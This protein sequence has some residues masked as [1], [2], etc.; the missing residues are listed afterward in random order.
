MTICYPVIQD[1]LEFCPREEL[2]FSD[3]PPTCVRVIPIY[4]DI[5]YV[6]GQFPPPVHFF[7]S[8]SGDVYQLAHIQSPPSV[9]PEYH[10]LLDSTGC[11]LVG[12][13]FSNLRRGKIL[14]AQIAVLPGVL[15]H[16]LQT[17]GLPLTSVQNGLPPDRCNPQQ[18]NQIVAATQNCLLQ[19]PPPPFDPCAFVL[20]CISGGGQP[21]QVQDTP[22]LDLTLTGNVLSGQVVV[23]PNAGNQLQVLPNGL[24]VSASASINVVDTSTVDLT[25]SGGNLSAQVVLNPSTNNALTATPTGLFVPQAPIQNVANT[26]TVALNVS[27]GT[28]TANA[29][30]APIA[31]NLLQALPNGLYVPP[32]V[33]TS[34]IINGGQGSWLFWDG[35]NYRSANLDQYRVPWGDV[36]NVNQGDLY[37]IFNVNSLQ[38]LRNNPPVPTAAS[39][40]LYISNDATISNFFG[41]NL[42][43]FQ[44]WTSVSNGA[45]GNSDLML[46]SASINSISAA[47]SSIKISRSS[48][49][50][51]LSLQSNVNVS[52]SSLSSTSI[53]NSNVIIENSNISGLF[54]FSSNCIGNGVAASSAFVYSSTV[55]SNINSSISGA[56]SVSMISDVPSGI[57]N[58]DFIDGFFGFHGNSFLTIPSQMQLRHGFAQFSTNQI[59]NVPVIVF[60]GSLVTITGS[61]S[62]NNGS[63][64]DIRDSVVATGGTSY[65]GAGNRIPST[66]YN[67]LVVGRLNLNTF[68]YLEAR[69]S[70]VA[71]S[72]STFSQ[73]PLTRS[74]YN[75][76]L[77]TG[78]NT[79]LTK[80]FDSGSIFVGAETTESPDN[81]LTV[82]GTMNLT[83]PE[84]NAGGYRILTGTNNI[85]TFEVWRSR[86]FLEQHLFYFGTDQASNYANDAAAVAI[87]NLNYGSDPRIKFG[88][89]TVVNVA[90]TPAI[91][92]WN[93]ATFVRITV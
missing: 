51:L 80:A 20:Q 22:T 53:S 7:I 91:F 1:R 32:P 41:Q 16:I 15:R 36:P 90:G 4:Q 10:A 23:S 65:G 66:V 9:P 89:M 45:A 56:L 85:R 82:V 44:Y 84:I 39:N 87:L 71:T 61:F 12:V 24:F 59:Q 67:S 63:W 88:T 30:I 81:L 60:Y 68:G 49:D 28:L 6:L 50:S 31:N 83:P 52:T 75:S 5:T 34:T 27:G 19:P 42:S 79:V 93:G 64:I 38:A 92:V 69:S 46:E 48:I 26:N 40:S 35:S 17:L 57:S 37:F 77:V 43:V 54:A 76:I 72:Q 13:E 86:G 47:N 78:E 58:L 70:L 14:P 33:P 74:E 62:S 73:A 11:I 29:V 2:T 55:L 25:F 18:W 3:T 8:D 21:L